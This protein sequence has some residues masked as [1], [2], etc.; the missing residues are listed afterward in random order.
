MRRREF[1]KTTAAG[2]SALGANSLA[3][4]FG[5][6]GPGTNIVLIMA[7]DLGREC[8]RCCGGI[9]YDTPHL[10]ELAVRGVRFDHCYSQPVC[11]PSRVQIMTG[12]YNH[13]NYEGFGYLN[14]REITFANLLRQ[15]GYAT[16]VAGKW[17]LSG[18]A[19]TVRDFGF[20]EHCLWNMHAYMGDGPDAREPKGWRK[21]YASPT[22]YVNGEWI[23]HGERD[24]GPDICCDF[25]CSFMERNRDEPFLVYYPMILT[26]SPFVPTPDSAGGTENKKDKKDKKKNFAD[27][28]RYADKI[29]G[30]IA[31]QLERLGLAERTLLLFTG[32]NGTDVK[33]ETN[34]EEGIV[35]GGKSHTTDAGTH[36]PLIASWPGVAPRGAR[37]D[38]LI[39]FSDFVPTLA[40]AA[41]AP[42]P[43]DRVID[44]RSFLPQIK[45]AKGSPRDWVF[46][47]YWKRGRERDKISEF[48][49]DKRWKLYGDGRFYDLKSDGAEENPL[50][51]MAPNAAAARKALERGF[52]QVRSRTEAPEKGEP[53][54]NPDSDRF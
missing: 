50:D 13:R 36:V 52:E 44:G 32:D 2:L 17:Q 24:F 12:R 8:L 14:S 49:R 54:S 7:D 43:R 26:H 4:G 22:L 1:L 33:I 40:E 39:D 3:H 9:D 20:D 10:D 53:C 37:C 46:C 29:V 27:M 34:T 19:S 23:A 28:V 51:T 18:D 35:K 15:A 5:G 16:C 31:N 47:H 30:R 45:G 6:P 48:V 41:G 42:L 25:V 21:R 38:D 11:T